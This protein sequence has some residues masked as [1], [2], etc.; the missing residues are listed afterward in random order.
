MIVV[1][2]MII[3]T[4]YCGI[5]M[6]TI[7]T[8]ESGCIDFNAEKYTITGGLLTWCFTNVTT[9]LGIC[10]TSYKHRRVVA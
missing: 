10:N 2:L 9:E 6:V 4:S 8:L 1:W 3:N 7:H 5:V